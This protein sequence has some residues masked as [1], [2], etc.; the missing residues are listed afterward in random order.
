MI[1]FNYSQDEEEDLEVCWLTQPRS[2]NGGNALLFGGSPSPSNGSYSA[3]AGASRPVVVPSPPL[4]IRRGFV[5]NELSSRVG[6][7]HVRPPQAVPPL[8]W[9]QSESPRS[10]PHQGEFS[11][12]H[13]QLHPS[14][15]EILERQPPPIGIG[16]TYPM[17]RTANHIPQYNSPLRGG[18][19]P[20]VRDGGGN[21]GVM[22]NAR[23]L[24]RP[25]HLSP[26][27]DRKQFSVAHPQDRFRPSSTATTTASTSSSPCT[28]QRSPATLYSPNSRVPR[29]DSTTTVE[30]FE[31]VQSHS[32]YGSQ[33]PGRK[34]KKVHR[35]RSP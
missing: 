30:S 26:P 21:P 18:S 11:A 7:L 10:N 35:Q 19:L 4:V 24:F 9:G 8:R 29:P 31:S 17:H 34:T 25:F 5:A 12:H 14:N 28:L 3:G 23:F 15:S 2:T 33:S 20:F 13:D 32:S 27:H 22:D 6:P 16:A 1:T